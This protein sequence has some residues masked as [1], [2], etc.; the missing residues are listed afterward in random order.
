MA[1]AGAT[2]VLAPP[3]RI[4]DC[5]ACKKVLS[6]ALLPDTPSVLNKLL[7][8]WSKLLGAAVL[9]AA[10]ALPDAVC[11]ISEPNSA[12]SLAVSADSW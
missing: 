11:E 9:L 7:K 8:L 4:L 5:R 10:L 1:A 12:P 3:P 6:E 2:G